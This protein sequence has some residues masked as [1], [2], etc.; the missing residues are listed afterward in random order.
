[1]VSATASQWNLVE[2]WSPTLFII[3]GLLLA[4]HAVMSGIHAF[5]NLSTPPDVFVTTGHF[6]AL[7]GLVGLY[8]A[9][10][11]RTPTLSRAAGAVAAVALLSWLVMT[12]TRF[13]SLT[14]SVSSLGEALPE[15]FF[16]VVLASTILTYLLFGVAILRVDDNSWIVGALVLA[17]GGLTAALVV[18]S[19]ISGV[20]ALDGFVIG[21]GLALSVLAVG[22]TLRSW[23]RPTSDAVTAADATAG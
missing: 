5:T 7:V 9:L 13:L 8:P 21:T 16:L 22:Y 11:H 10:V 20:T 6:V 12:V 15:L 4:G 3:G 17:P 2:R 18:D 1:M 19:V 14:G 23:D